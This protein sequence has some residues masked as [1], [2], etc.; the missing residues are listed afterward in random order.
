MAVAF[1]DSELGPSNPKSNR[2]AA[3]DAGITTRHA[4]AAAS[5]IW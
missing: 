2:R 3:F 1:G 4:S 5:R